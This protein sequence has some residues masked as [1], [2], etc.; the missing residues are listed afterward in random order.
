MAI[1]SDAVREARVENSPPARPLQV[2]LIEDSLL[3]REAVA[4]LVEADGRARVAATA[5]S[6]AAAIGELRANAYDVVIVDLKL[7][8]GSGFGVLRALQDL[9]REVLAVV[10]TN[11][12]TPAVRKRC[13]ELGATWFFDKSSEFEEIGELIAKQAAQHRVS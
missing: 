11:Y 2:L 13:A 4:E 10:F 1:R 7:R 6:E 12:A 5:D 9:Q 3:I 8:E